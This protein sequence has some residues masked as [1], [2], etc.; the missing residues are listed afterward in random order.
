MPITATG[1]LAAKLKRIREA[2]PPQRQ[3]QFVA[4]GPI[5]KDKPVVRV[6]ASLDQDDQL[7]QAEWD[8]LD[9]DEFQRLS[10]EDP[11]AE[12]DGIDISDMIVEPELPESL[13]LD[14]ENGNVP[15]LVDPSTEVE[16]DLTDDAEGD[17]ELADLFRA[18]FVLNKAPTDEQFHSLAEA[19]GMDYTELENRLYRLIGNSLGDESVGTHEIDVD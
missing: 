12:L 14:D 8:A 5:E 4:A 13:E 2:P 15:D 6:K 9:E 17:D 16:A 1:G 19:I 7:V 10:D 11:P 3:R 18:F